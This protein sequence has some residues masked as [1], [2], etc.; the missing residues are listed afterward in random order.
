MLTYFQIISDSELFT[1]HI[2]E[3]CVIPEELIA[4]KGLEVIY[5]RKSSR[6]IIQDAISNLYYLRF[7]NLSLKVC[8]DNKALHI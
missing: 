1:F 3:Y 2:A 7:I 8:E 5:F 4:D 6:Y